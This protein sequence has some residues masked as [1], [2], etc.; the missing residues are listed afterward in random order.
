MTL[1]FKRGKPKWLMRFPL[2]LFFWIAAFI[3]LAMAKPALHPGDIHFTF[4][5]L[6]NMGVT[7]CP[8]CGLGRAITLIFQGSFRE[9][10]KYHWLGIPAVLII[11][12]RIVI[13][14]RYQW[15]K[16]MNKRKEK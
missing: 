10:L 3:F 15:N 2:E 11:G 8:G 12:Y 4:C 5:P 1:K 14:G 13:L 16:I 9:S 6:A 7:W